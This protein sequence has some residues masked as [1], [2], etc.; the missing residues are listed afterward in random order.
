MA[1][2]EPDPSLLSRLGNRDSEISEGDVAR[3][4]G[5]AF[6]RVI[7]RVTRRSYWQLCGPLY[8]L[9]AQRRDG[10]DEVSYCGALFGGYNVARERAKTY[11]VRFVFAAKL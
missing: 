3:R 9:C 5:R 1:G 11:Y 4:R 6:E 10:L 8:W 2:A 7:R